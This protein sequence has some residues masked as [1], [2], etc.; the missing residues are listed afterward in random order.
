MATCRRR[1]GCGL[2]GPRL[3]GPPSVTNAPVT[4]N[5]RLPRFPPHRKANYGSKPGRAFPFRVGKSPALSRCRFTCA[6][7]S[8]SGSCPQSCSW[9]RSNFKWRSYH[10]GRPS[11]RV[12]SAMKRTHFRGRNRA[13]QGSHFCYPSYFMGCPLL[14][15]LCAGFADLLSF[16]GRKTGSPRDGPAPALRPPRPKPGKRQT[17]RESTKIA[18]FRRRGI[19]LA[20][21]IM[22]F[23]A[24]SANLVMSAS[25]LKTRLRT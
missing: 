5:K 2:R 24:H 4:P 11:R 12:P 7:D 13:C 18:P 22:A 20:A 23:V 6:S 3:V 16:E 9:L 19:G 15:R 1:L 17:G 25:A 8:D 10:S 21:C 14:S